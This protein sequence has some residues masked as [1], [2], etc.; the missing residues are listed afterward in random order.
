MR[1]VAGVDCHKSSHTAV[2]LDAAGQ[3]ID[4]VTFR[5]Q[6]RGYERAPPSRPA[7][8]LHLLGP[9]RCRLLRVRVQRGR[10]SA[11]RHASGDPASWRSGIGGTA[12]AEESRTRRTRRR[13]PR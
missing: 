3:V 2:F 9:R 13:S 5:R 4:R 10:A 11:R 6:N 1:V 7:A 8:R 12:A